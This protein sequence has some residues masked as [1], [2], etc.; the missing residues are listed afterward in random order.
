MIRLSNG[1]SG[2]N[3]FVLGI[4]IF[5]LGLFVCFSYLFVDANL[6]YLQVLS[7]GF[8]GQHRLIASGMFVFFLLCFYGLYI[9]ILSRIQKEALRTPA[10]LKL[11]LIFSGVL[12]FAYPAVTS[13]DIFNYIASA[14]TTFFYGENPYII[15][16]IT[17]IGDPILLFT[18]AANK[19]ALYG[20]FWI[21]LTGVP[22]LLSVGNYIV[23]IFLF[24]AL[25][26]SFYFGILYMIWRITRNTFAVVFFGLNP[27][28]LFE[29]AVAGHNDVVMMFFAL[30]ALYLY[31]KEHKLLSIF[32]VF[33]SILIKYATIVL[34]PIFLYIFWLQ[35]NEKKINWEVVYLLCAIAMTGI[36]LLAPI[37]EE[38][39]PWYAVWFLSFIALFTQR[40]YFVTSSIIV[41]FFLLLRYIPYMYLGTHFGITPVIKIFLT[42]APVVVL[43]L[44]V[45]HK[46]YLL[47]PRSSH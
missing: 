14:K 34:I 9:Y 30:S 41:S 7:K 42:F 40:K 36:F 3:K 39:Y 17:F 13:Y 20:P 5:L 6:I 28:V 23:A 25:V 22:F 33:C 35:K 46:K 27:L 8:A 21:L 32:M 12:L 43:L 15:M 11:L 37:R 24:K 10:V 26:I 2:M 29:T 16:P 19:V 45:A 47:R 31:K 44:F 38:I 1:N 18:H 4:S